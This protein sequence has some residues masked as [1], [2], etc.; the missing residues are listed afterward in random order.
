MNY[1]RTII[2]FA[3]NVSDSM[4]R[5]MHSTMRWTVVKTISKNVSISFGKEKSC[6]TKLSTTG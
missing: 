5:E 1:R 2:T 6:K 3:A 4:K